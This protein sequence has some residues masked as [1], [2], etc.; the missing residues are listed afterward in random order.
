MKATLNL[1]RSMNPNSMSL[2]FERRD[3]TMLIHTVAQ[4]VTDEHSNVRVTQHPWPCPICERH[5][6]SQSEFNRDWL[7]VLQKGPVS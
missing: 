2:G 7:V 5:G 4:V 3:M 1:Y 6:Y